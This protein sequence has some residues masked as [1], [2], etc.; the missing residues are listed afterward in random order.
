MGI[1]EKCVKSPWQHFHPM[2]IHQNRFIITDNAYKQTNPE[3]ENVI[4]GNIVI[5]TRKENT[6]HSSVSFEYQY[7]MVVLIFSNKEK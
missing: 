4:N 5:L 1:Y 7:S 3:L 6:F 2:N